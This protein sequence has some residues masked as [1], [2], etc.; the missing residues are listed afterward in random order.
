MAANKSYVKTVLVDEAE[1]DRLQQQQLR[2]Y[3]PEL[4]SISLLKSDMDNISTVLIF[5]LKRTN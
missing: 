3:S 2:E 4:V 5:R 1:L